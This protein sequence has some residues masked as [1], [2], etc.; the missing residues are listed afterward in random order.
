MKNKNDEVFNSEILFIYD[1]KMCN[2]NG[3]PD[4]ENKPR[5]DYE[6]SRNLVSDVR[7]KRYI[8][9]YFLSQGYEIY[10]SKVDDETVDATERIEK[11]REKF[12]K[13]I[14]GRKEELTKEEIKWLLTKLIDVRL[15]GATI[16]IKGQEKGV[17]LNF[18]G[19]VQFSWGYSLNPVEIMPSSSITSIFAGRTTEGKEEYG[20]IGKDWRVYYSLIAF[21]GI[22]SKKRAN[23]TLLT[24]E[25]IKLLDNA[26]INAIPSEATTRSKLGQTP[27][28]LLRIE[29]TSGNYIGDL[30]KFVKIQPKGN[31]KLE[32][33]REID[34]FSLDITKLIEIINQ[35]EDRISKVLYWQHPELSLLKDNEEVANFS[36][37]LSEKFKGRIV[38]LPHSN[39][40]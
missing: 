8:R 14:K 33:L 38:V 7:L 12:E 25:D 26:L 4:E 24:N 13:E 37:I 29:Y 35:N 1:A 5:M 21:Y 16:P 22:I 19:P 30:R 6:T 34:E 23:K 10:V 9:D 2:P 20:T 32:I 17:S 39:S 31:K 18:T 15:F 27:R 36:N 11:F 3:D 28:F 40:N